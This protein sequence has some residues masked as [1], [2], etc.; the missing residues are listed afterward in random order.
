MRS[1][2]GSMRAWLNTANIKAKFWEVHSQLDEDVFQAISDFETD[3]IPCYKLLFSVDQMLEGFHCDIDGLFVFR[4][5]GSISVFIQMMGFETATGD[6]PCKVVLDFVN[7][8]DSANL[9]PFATR[10]P[11]LSYAADA[12]EP[13]PAYL[14][15]SSSRAA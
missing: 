1:M 15:A 4:P 10:L 5:T 12:A 11:A 9:P 3:D 13:R 14:S 8:I 6:E 2:M 7:N